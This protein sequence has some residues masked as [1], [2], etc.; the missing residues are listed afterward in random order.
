MRRFLTNKMEIKK[1]I[2]KMIDNKAHIGQDSL[3]EL[4]KEE[5]ITL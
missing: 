5:I 4:N 3:N 2:A 1:K